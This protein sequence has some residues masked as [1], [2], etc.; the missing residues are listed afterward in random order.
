[1]GSGLREN[2]RGA[3]RRGGRCF[4]AGEGRSTVCV[5]PARRPPLLPGRSPQLWR[6]LKTRGLMPRFCFSH[7]FGSFVRP[8]TFLLLWGQLIKRKSA[9][10]APQAARVAWGSNLQAVHK[11][12]A[13]AALATGGRGLCGAAG[14]V[15][16]L[17]GDLSPSRLCS[18]K[19]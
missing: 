18:A 9:G 10:S 3:D 19:A 17:S 5:V 1:M 4:V 14:G 11:G 7:R 15:S 2:S 6:D 16:V 8:A 12:C 13:G